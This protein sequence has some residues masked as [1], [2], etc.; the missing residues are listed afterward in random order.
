MRL[1]FLTAVTLVLLAPASWA[2]T[3]P[4]GNLMPMPKKLVPGTGVLRIE[5]SFRLAF[6]GTPTPRLQRAGRRLIAQIARETGMPLRATSSGGIDPATLVV[7]CP[8]TTDR[9]DALGNNESYS[10]VITS[11]QA[12]ISAPTTVGAMRGMQTFL[13]LISPDKVSFSAPAVHIEDAPRFGWRG[14]LFDVTSH[15]LPVDVILRNLDAMEAVKLNV[16]HLHMTDDQGFRV[17]S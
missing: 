1:A 7:D 5:D 9:P 12:R 11:S 13:Q 2:A 10:L 3:A 15:F 16:L 14:L 6:A 8:E 17:E 4:A